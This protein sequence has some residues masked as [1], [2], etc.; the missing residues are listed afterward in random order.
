MMLSKCNRKM[1]FSYRNAIVVFFY[2]RILEGSTF[3]SYKYP[4]IRIQI[5]VCTDA[6]QH[7]KSIFGGNGVGMDNYCGFYHFKPI[8]ENDLLKK[9]HIEMG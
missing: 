6:R 5:Y 8:L 9:I 3:F 7:P 2:V 4:Y 1:L